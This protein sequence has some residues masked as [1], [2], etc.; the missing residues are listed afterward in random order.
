MEWLADLHWP[1]VTP[2]MKGLTY[3]GGAGAI[4]FV[5]G[6]AMAVW[7]RRPLLLVVLVVSLRLSAILDGVL[8][9]AIGRQ[10]PPL[11]DSHV[12]PLITVPHDPS[13]PSGHAMMAFTGAVFLGAVVPRFRWPLLVLAAGIALSRVYLGVHYPS[14]V[15]VGAALGAGIGA[16]AAVALRWGE[17]AVRS[18]RRRAVH[19]G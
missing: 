18:W 9:R 19:P 17:G 8:K 2:V 3:A 11:A 7:L 15:L 14:D 10:R 5:I 1:V 12:H 6:A 4:W 16:V 13:M